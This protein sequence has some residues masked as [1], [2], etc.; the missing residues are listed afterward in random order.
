MKSHI[1]EYSDAA[2][3]KIIQESHTYKECF[4]KMG[5]R[6]ISGSLFPKF[7]R[8]VEILG[9]SVE[10][11][12][13]PHP[14]KLSADDVFCKNSTVTGC[15]LRDW[16]KKDNNIPYVCSICGQEPFWNNKPMTLILDHINGYNH[17]N[18]IENLRWVCPNCNIQLD[19]TN[20]K[21]KNHGIR[22]N[23]YHCCIDCGKQITAKST[24]CRACASKVVAQRHERAQNPHS[25]FKDELK[26]L[27]RTLPFVHVGKHYNITDNAVRKWCKK[28]GLPFRSSEIKT[29][30]DEE[31]ETL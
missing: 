2:F 23:Q 9:L 5:Y 27:I 10:H 30:T 25:I 12:R 29:M 26:E 28:F 20:G 4:Q 8:R 1:E 7:K 31:W 3:I 15:V 17:D 13:K 19:T 22:N 24:R 14:R 16:Y 18:R 6:A 21:N 11:F